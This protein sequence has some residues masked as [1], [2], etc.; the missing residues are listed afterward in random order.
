M[1][2]SWNHYPYHFQTRPSSDIIPNL[3]QLH[4]LAHFST[5]FLQY[6][7]CPNLKIHSI[8]L[9][10]FHED[11]FDDISSFWSRSNCHLEELGISF[12]CSDTT[13]IGYQRAPPPSVHRL[14]QATATFNLSLTSLSL[15]LA[16]EP[17][18]SFLVLFLQ[19]LTIVDPYT[20]NISSYY[21]PFM[22][23]LRIVLVQSQFPYEHMKNLVNGALFDMLRSRRQTEYLKNCG[24]TV[25]QAI[26]L[27]L[28]PW[29]S[30][31]VLEGF[32]PC[33]SCSGSLWQWVSEGMEIFI[34][35]RRSFFRISPQRLYF[36]F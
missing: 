13:G 31:L 2:G 20:G 34:L 26:S 32:W 9:C 19:L 27:E 15:Q 4:T 35:A 10:G 29:P 6:I 25:L 28:V 22:T 12:L 21:F 36:D 1:V 14:I 7:Q 8:E 3:K 18:R 17:N 30:R 16:F 24:A 23:R 11:S 33:L 5:S